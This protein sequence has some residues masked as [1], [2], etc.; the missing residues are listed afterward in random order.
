MRLRVT[1]RLDAQYQ[2]YKDA[3]TF[4]SEVLLPWGT[5]CA[6][7]PETRLIGQPSSGQI[8]NAYKNPN[9]PPPVLLRIYETIPEA[10]RV[11]VGEPGI[12]YNQYGF[13]EVVLT[14]IQFN[15][16]AS[17]SDVVGSSTAP[18]PYAAA[19]LKTVDGSNDGTI[20]TYKLTYTTGGLMSDMQN[21]RFGGKVI[22][23]TLKSLNQIPA[24]PSGFTLVGPGVEYVSGLPLYIYEYAAAAGSGGTPGTSGQIS[25]GFTNNQG[26]NIPFDISNPDGA[27]G[28]VICVTAAVSPQ[29][30]TSNPVTQPTGFVLWAVDVQDESGY[31]LW[32]TKSSFGGGNPITVDVD[33]QSDGALIYTVSQNDADGSTIPAYPGSGTAYNTKLTHTRDNGFFR[34]TAIW[35]KLPA[36][37]TLLQDTQFEKPGSAVFTGSPPQLVITA[38]V[39]MTILAEMEVSYD[40]AQLSD[41]PFTVVEPA[42]FYEA[43]TPTDTGIAVNSTQALGR[44]LAGASGISGTNSVYNGILCDVWEATLGSSTPSSFSL[45]EKVLSTKNTPYLT[46]VDGVVVYRRIKVSY[47]FS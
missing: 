5:Q 9:D 32:T 36:T 12:S 4:A 13:L 17:Y 16:G 41:V 34:N 39:T 25:R 15:G 33:G 43:Y 45:D 6:A 31:R 21:L 46:D 20:R 23:R 19:V 3:A 11:L 14:Y 10:D 22:V 40:E 35:H 8:E 38:P 7:Y 2:L 27:T 26:G 24:T 37:Q 47:D 42:T 18:A 28:E 30:E 1:E 29:S 44:Y